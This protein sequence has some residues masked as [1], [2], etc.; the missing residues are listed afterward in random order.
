LKSDKFEEESELPKRFMKSLSSKER[1]KVIVS[2]LDTTPY[3]SYIAMLKTF[4]RVIATFELTG[5]KEALR[6]YNRNL[7][8]PGGEALHHSFVLVREAIVLD[9]LNE[10][11]SAGIHAIDETLYGLVYSLNH[12][13]VNFNHDEEYHKLMH[14][15]LIHAAPFKWPEANNLKVLFGEQK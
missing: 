11:S 13:D 7:T 14:R 4:K 12:E 15:F 5:D 3:S 10:D 6:I 9:L 1:A 2:Y 8:D